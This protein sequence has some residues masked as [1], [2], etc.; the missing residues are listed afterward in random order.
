MKKNIIKITSLAFTVM[1]F[2]SCTPRIIGS[3]DIQKFETLKAGEQSISLNNIGTIEFHKNG[4]G[5]KNINYSILGI[6][7][8]D[9]NS[10]TWKWSENKFVT[11][12][13]EGSDITKTWIIIANKKKFQKWKS[14]DG[15]NQVQ[16]LELKKQQVK[17]K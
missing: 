15:A 8:S 9:P 3:W 11:L 7:H 5:T 17:V 1:L 6:S 4:T 13:G 10:F 16:T 14:T 2:A 12:E